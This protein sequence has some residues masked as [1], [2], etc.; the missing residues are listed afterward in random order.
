MVILMNKCQTVNIKNIPSG[1]E[2]VVFK[3]APA[4][5]ISTN[6]THTFSL[7]LLKIPSRGKTDFSSHEYNYLT[8]S[9]IQEFIPSFK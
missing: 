8:S 1:F 5:W 7:F 9:P 6:L 4:G 2:E 3:V